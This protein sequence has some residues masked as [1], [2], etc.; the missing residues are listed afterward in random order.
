MG[1]VKDVAVHVRKEIKR[2]F[3]LSAP[4]VPGNPLDNGIRVQRKVLASASPSYIAGLASL[5][6]ASVYALASAG[7]RASVA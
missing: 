2:L 5:G 4:F 7:V 3:D 1:R 6:L